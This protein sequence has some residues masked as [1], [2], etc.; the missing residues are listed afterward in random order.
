MDFFRLFSCFCG[1]NI[2]TH[3]LFGSNF[4]KKEKNQCAERNDFT[5]SLILAPI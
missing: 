4:Q 3:A 1:K 2:K 5:R